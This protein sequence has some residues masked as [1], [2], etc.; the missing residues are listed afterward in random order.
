VEAFNTPVIGRVF[1]RVLLRILGTPA[2]LAVWLHT[3]EE[4]AHARAATFD[5]FRRGPHGIRSHRRMRNNDVPRC[6]FFTE[7]VGGLQ[8]SFV[9]GNKNLDVITDLGHFGG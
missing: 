1:G 2:N 7:L 8:Q 6:E 5:N 9:V 4:A 3:E